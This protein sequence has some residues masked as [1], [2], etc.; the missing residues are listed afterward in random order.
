M[1]HRPEVHTHQ[2]LFLTRGRKS[3]SGVLMDPLGRVVSVGGSPE[4]GRAPRELWSGTSSLFIETQTHKITRFEIDVP[5]PA[6]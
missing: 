4:S 1:F 5:Q 6:Y 2:T 3:W